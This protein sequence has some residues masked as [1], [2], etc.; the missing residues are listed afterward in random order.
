MNSKILVVMAMPEEGGHHFED[1]GIAIEYIGLGKVNAAYRSTKALFKHKPKLVVNFGTAG[2]K[3]FN[4]GEM[5]AV[6]TFIQR[7]MDV[8]PLGFAPG[9]TPFENTPQIIVHKPTFDNLPQGSCGTGDSFETNH[10]HDKGDVVDMEAYA[11]AKVCFLENI[12]FACV[13]FI[14]D[15]ADDKASEHWE[16][17]LK[18]VPTHFLEIFKK[19]FN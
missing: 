5:V 4:R 15:G 8:S 19:Q 3:K 12:D 6:H 1:A 7:D 13:K 11:L 9:V 10:S 18:N 2:S 17:S 14:S 16:E